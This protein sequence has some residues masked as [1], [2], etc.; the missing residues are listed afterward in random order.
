MGGGA[1]GRRWRGRQ[2]RRRDRPRGGGSTGG[3]TG[4]G[5]GGSTGGTTGPAGAAYRRPLG[6]TNSRVTPPSV[7]G[8]P[9]PAARGYGNAYGDPDEGRQRPG[10]AGGGDQPRGRRQGAHV[11]AQGRVHLRHRPLRHAAVGARHEPRRLQGP[12]TRVRRTTVYQHHPQS[13][14][15]GTAD[16]IAS[17]SAERARRELAVPVRGPAVVLQA[18][19]ETSRTGRPR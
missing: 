9:E 15:I 6:C 19:A 7:V 5:T 18:E 3:T 12:S 16:T 1:A 10:G 13:H 14:K 11:R 2:H 8:I 17:S 4:R